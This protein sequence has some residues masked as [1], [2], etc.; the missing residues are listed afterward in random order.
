MYQVSNGFDDLPLI[1]K[2]N[3]GVEMLTAKLG[4][5]KLVESE[6]KIAFERH[7]DNYLWAK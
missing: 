4:S 3:N 2:K 6:T 1:I 7:P 5:K